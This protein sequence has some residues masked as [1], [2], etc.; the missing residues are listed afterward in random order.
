MAG[1][2]FINGSTVIPVFINMMTSNK[3]LVGLAITLGSFTTYFGRL[4]VGPFVPHIKNHARYSMIVMFIC[5]PMILLP[6]LFLLANADALL[7]VWMFILAYS[8][9]W[10]CD[11]LVSPS[12][13]EILATT[14]DGHRRGR[15]MGLQIVI[16]GVAGILA[17]VIIKALMNAPNGDFRHSFFLI[18]LIGGIFMTLSCC[19]MAL[20]RDGEH[21]VQTGKVMFFNYYKTL[22]SH[23]KHEKK[24]TTMMIAQI[25]TIV[26]AMSGP[27]VILFA[28]ETLHIGSSLL[29]TL[30]IVQL[31][32]SPVG[33]YVWGFICDKLGNRQAIIMGSLSVMMVPLLTLCALLCRAFIPPIFFLAPAIFL[34]GGNGGTWLGY[35]NYLV[36]AVKPESRPACIVLSGV[37]T[38]PTSFTGYLAGFISSYLGYIPL[39]TIAIALSILGF[40]ASLKIKAADSKRAETELAS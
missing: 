38:L 35:Y 13:F 5:R 31:I 20:A 12:W 6:V 9:I 26:G 23:L 16:G 21:E 14:I 37:L 40:F 30:I 10:I 2:A 39:F 8:A 19:C 32:G 24:F 11:G 7:T 17:G 3:E 33:G 1:V 34:L 18:F 22:P 15:L 25:I 29:S 36:A 28:D 4:L 27:F